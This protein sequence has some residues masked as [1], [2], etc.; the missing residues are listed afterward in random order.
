MD[1]IPFDDAV[2][3][4]ISKN[5]KNRYAIIWLTGILIL[6]LVLYFPVVNYGWIT[7]PDQALIIDNY[8]VQSLRSESLYDIFFSSP[9]GKYAPLSFL[10]LAIDISLSPTQVNR[11]IHIMNLLLHILNVG[12]FFSF[13]FLFTKRG[14]LAAFA[15]LIFSI[16]PIHNMTVTL[17]SSRSYVLGAFFLLLALIAYI[18]STRSSPGRKGYFNLSLIFYVLALLSHPVTIIFPLAIVFIDKSMNREMKAS[19]WEKLPVMLLSILFLVINIYTQW[20]DIFADPEGYSQ[21]VD[22]VLYSPIAFSLLFIKTVIPYEL[23]IYHPMPEGISFLNIA[24]AVMVIVT[25]LFTFIKFRNHPGV[26]FSLVFSVSGL[27]L[28][29]VLSISEPVWYSE[30]YA[31]IPSMGL[32]LLLGILIQSLYHLLSRQ[33]NRITYL[34]LIIPAA[35]VLTLAYVTHERLILFKSSEAI[36]T[37]MITKYPDNDQGYF[38][39]GDYW[40]MNG[41]FDRAKFDYSQCIRRNQGAYEALNNLGLI[42]MEEGDTRLAIGEFNKALQAN[43][44]FFKSHLNKGI[45]QMRMEKNE[46]ALESMNEAISLKP[47]NSLA[48]YNRGLV[49]ERLNSL[50]EAINDFSS[51]IQ[52]NPYQIIFY[53]DRGK[54]HV[55]MRNFAAAELDYSKAIVLDPSNAEMWFRRSLARSSQD[56]YAEGLED[57]LMAQS[58]GFP[59]EEEYIRGLSAEVLKD[60]LPTEN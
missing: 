23:S 20:S 55:W 17:M 36:W 16:H 11:H 42:Y 27:L 5:K 1:N 13:V 45:A 25:I 14:L 6:T 31:Y 4:D 43:P 46:L 8:S 21:L 51:A 12:L 30:K 44:G 34:V 32:F 41:R 24:V 7:G 3:Q 22:K 59:V 29:L 15:A 18:Y 47:K 50:P 54:A 53:K 35:Y 39:R 10:S 48:Y 37:D 49:Y 40:A 19:L 9:E 38:R 60:E 52:L 2:I 33:T 26:N 56:K 57:A 28:A 58:L